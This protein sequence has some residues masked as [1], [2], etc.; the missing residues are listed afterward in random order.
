MA[1]IGGLCQIARDVDIR[2][3]LDDFG[4]GYSS[5]VSRALSR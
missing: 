2:V 5:P 4:T 3:G 1:V